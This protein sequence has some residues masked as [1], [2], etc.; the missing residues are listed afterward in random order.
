MSTRIL[1]FTG[2]S[3]CFSEHK[4]DKDKGD[5]AYSSVA[6][7]IIKNPDHILD[8][9]NLSLLRQVDESW[10]LDVYESIAIK[11]NYDKHQLNEELG[12]VHSVLVDLFSS[13]SQ[14]L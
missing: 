9:R 4:G 3:K 6:K 11:Q 5:A 12:N 14:L 10:K 2:T 1:A 8:I 13:T 7:H